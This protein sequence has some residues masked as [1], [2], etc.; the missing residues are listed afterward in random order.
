MEENNYTLE[1]M[2]ADYQQLKERLENQEIIN[3]KL[4]REAMGGKVR[5]MRGTVGW[6]VACGVFVLIT[7]PFIFHYNPLINASWAFTIATMLMMAFCIFLDWKFNHK[8]QGTDISNCDMLTFSKHVREMKNYYAGWIKWAFVII[9]FWAGWLIAEVLLHVE[10]KKLAIPM[11]VGML[12][13]LV[14]GGLIGY[15]M[16][17]KIIRTCSEIIDEIEN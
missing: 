3:D 7:A 9:V 15:R 12:I 5:S 2:R 16:D 14:A 13:G 11:V 17:R 6:S 8:V 4:M 10:E 1:Q